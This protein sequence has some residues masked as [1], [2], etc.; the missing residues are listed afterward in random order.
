MTLLSVFYEINTEHYMKK[1]LRTIAGCLCLL[2]IV[3][4][5]AETPDGGI[6][7]PWTLGLL[8]AGTIGAIILDRTSHERGR[9]G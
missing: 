3:L 9:R 5:G 8:A 7:L 4:A 1:A 6:C 2:A